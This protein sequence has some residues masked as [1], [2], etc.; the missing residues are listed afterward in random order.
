MS[1]PKHAISFIDPIFKLTRN[2]SNQT[3]SLSCTLLDPDLK[4]KHTIQ[5]A[6]EVEDSLLTIVVLDLIMHY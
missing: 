5:S 1:F 3:P 4:Q 6:F 2:A